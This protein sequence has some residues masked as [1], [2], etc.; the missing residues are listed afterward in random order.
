[1]KVFEE[2]L[3]VSIGILL[4]AGVITL[5]FVISSNYAVDTQYSIAYRKKDAQESN[6]AWIP[7]DPYLDDE[8]FTV[9]S[10]RSTVAYYRGRP[11]YK[12]AGL[13]IE[14][15]IV[16]HLA[17]CPAIPGQNGYITVRFIINCEGQIGRIRLHPLDKNFNPTLFPDLQHRLVAYLSGLGKWEPY[18]QDGKT[19][20][21]ISHLHCKVTDGKIQKVSR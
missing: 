2:K 3:W 9:C 12:E 4:F 10:E 21:T 7:C 11:Q 15:L 20:D 18:T 6:L 13:S 14:D 17:D 5:A 1:M 8:S 19:Y 16:T